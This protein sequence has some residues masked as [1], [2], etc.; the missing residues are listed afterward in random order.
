MYRGRLLTLAAA[1]AAA[2]IGYARLCK[3]L[4]RGWPATEALRL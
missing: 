4:E 1:A 3:R 2:G